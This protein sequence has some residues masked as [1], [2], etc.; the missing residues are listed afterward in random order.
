MISSFSTALSGLNAMSTAIDIV[1]NNLANLN[2]T[3]YKDDTASFK[4]LVAQSLSGNGTSQVGLGTTA[5]LTN[6]V[7]SQGTISA[8]QGNLDAAINGNGFFIVKNASGQNLFTRDG[9]FKVDTNGYL[10]TSTGELVQ[11]W[12]AQNLVLNTSGALGNIQTPVGQSL[13]PRATTAF[14]LAGNLDSSAQSGTANGTFGQQI[15]AYDSLGNQTPLTVSFAKDPLIAGQWNYSVTGPAGTAVANGTGSVQFNNQTGIMTSPTTA[16]GNI[17]LTVSGL[18]DGAA[19]MNINWNLYN[20]DNTPKF[21]GYSEASSVSSNTQDG[22]PAAQLTGVT[23]ADGGQIVA[24]YSNGAQQQVVAQVALAG[25][26]NPESLVDVGNN[27]F[28]LGSDTAAPAIGISGTGGRGVIDGKSLEGSTV[29]IATE[30]ANLLVYQRSYQA[31]SRVVTVSDSLAQE[32][33]NLVHA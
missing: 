1:G 2:T 5:P 7:F 4:D 31:N 6:R 14:S 32:A 3:G 33:V 22:Q 21:T 17:A 27:N 10:T 9:S 24:S 8:T 29:D 16:N 23:L 25:V 26:R 15:Q 28:T 19:N 18:S 13:P 12:S 20:P 30:F 11:G